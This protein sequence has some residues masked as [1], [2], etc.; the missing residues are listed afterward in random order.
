MQLL[1]LK[2]IALA[3]VFSAATTFAAKAQ[4]AYTE[5]E[6]DYT[7]V[8]NG[9][10]VTLQTFFKGDSTV[11]VQHRGPATISILYNDKAPFMGVLIDVPVAGM[12]KAAIATPADLE[13]MADQLP[14]FAF[15]TTTETQ[16]IGDYNC[17]KVIAKDNKSGKSF[18]IWITTDIG[19][20]VN[21]NT[22]AFASLGGVPVKFTSLFMG[23]VTEVTLN[24]IKTDPV[25]PGTFAVPADFDKITFDELKALSGGRR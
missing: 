8:A 23:I 22:K 7:A 17:K 10:T 9:Q 15:T 5:G 19:V 21:I 6:I 12:K 11:T 3:V 20:P 2:N 18:D 1:N 14:D 25:K 4:K 24:T 16:K 13:G